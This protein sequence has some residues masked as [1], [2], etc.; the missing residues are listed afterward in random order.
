MAWYSTGTVAVTENSPT[1]TGTGTQFSS[2][3]RVGDAFI[4]PDGRLYEVS[5][6]AS[7]TVMSIKPNYQ[8]STASGQAYAVAPILGYDKD[9]SD[10]FNLIANQWGGTLAGIQPWATAPTPAAARTDLGA[11]PLASPALTGNPT[12]PTPA[13]TDNDTSIATT[14]YVKNV[15]ATNGLGTDS[16]SSAVGDLNEVRYGGITAPAGA[17]NAPAG[18]LIL[19]SGGRSGGAR[20]SQFAID[21]SLNARAFIRG[22]NSGRPAAEQW[23][24]WKELFH[25]GNI[26]GTVSRS[27]GAPTGAIIERGSNANGEYVRF[28]DGTQIC[29]V[30][31]LGNGSQQPGTPITLPLPAAFLGNYTTG[32]SVSWAP[33][34]SAPS[35]A[36][37]VKVAYANGSTLF[38][39]LQDALRTNRLIFTLVGR[40]F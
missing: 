28:A 3:V 18:E 26:L 25:T 1:V 2:N 39:T 15:L 29:I 14:G 21:H 16:A 38:F 7:S 27:G 24:P 37:G 33:H 6:V 13:A 5:N 12:A 8:G 32:V 22:Y 23:G 31:L 35:V 17:S 10:R 40:W 30:T 34:V 19:W 20:A 4:A 36:N 11:A 9:L